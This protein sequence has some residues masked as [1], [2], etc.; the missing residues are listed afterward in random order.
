MSHKW[1]L[2]NVKSEIKAQKKMEVE[3]NQEIY[4]INVK[5]EKNDGKSKK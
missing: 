4:L 5:K 1:A 2:T 3:G